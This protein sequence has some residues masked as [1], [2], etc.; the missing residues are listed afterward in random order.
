MLPAAW[1][2]GW[3]T[4][5]LHHRMPGRYLLGDLTTRLDLRL[6]KLPGLLKVQP[7]LRCRP[8]NTRPAATPYRRTDL[9][10]RRRR[11]MNDWAAYL[12]GESR[13]PEAGPGR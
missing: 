1:G 4:P 11:F 5:L 7:E 3:V 9:F 2:Q 8:E 12:A 6:A 13:D 10:E